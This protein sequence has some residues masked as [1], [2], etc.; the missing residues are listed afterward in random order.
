MPIDVRQLKHFEA[1]YRYRNFIKAAREL[2]ITQSALT[3]SIKLL[4]SSVGERL[5]DRTTQSVSPTETGERLVGHAKDVISS[6]HVFEQEV[7]SLRG[8]ESGR[9]A[10]GSG[11]YPLQMLLTNTI[12]AFGNKHPRVQVA[13]HT[14]GPRELL[15]RL[16]NR[17]LDMVICDISKFETMPFANL[18][19][20]EPLPVEPLVVVHHEAHPVANKQIDLK[21]LRKYP[22]A[23]PKSSPYFLRHTD[24]ADKNREAEH[25]YPQYLIEVPSVCLELAKQGKVL[26]AVP[27][28]LA[29]DVCARNSLAMS[30]LPSSFQTN[31]GVHTLKGKT[32]GPAARE[33]LHHIFAEAKASR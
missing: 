27:K 24:Q 21:D 28:S 32:L 13:L 12:K 4:E 6:L 22:W 33:F 19:K 25:P 8:I 29:K 15:D 30:P 2:R 1:V 11:P 26:T 10:V 3:K 31:D 9:V 17:Q 20:I 23:L 5:F 18:L 7:G 14:G 16:I